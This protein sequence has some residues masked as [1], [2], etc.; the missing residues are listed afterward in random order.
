MNDHEWLRTAAICRPI[1]PQG[2]LVGRKVLL[3][4]R[5]VQQR[6]GN[7]GC[8]E[9]RPGAQA[10][11]PSRDTKYSRV[12]GHGW[13]IAN[14]SRR[15]GKLRRIK[16]S[17]WLWSLIPINQIRV[18]SGVDQTKN[19]DCR[20]FSTELSL[21]ERT[22]SL[23]RPHEIFLAG[24]NVFLHSVCLESRCRYNKTLKKDVP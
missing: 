6:T 23:L 21:L 20:S 15:R 17:P 11:R 13:T 3:N 12:C 8:L 19:D 24:C 9:S 7:H 16:A 1:L 4:F 5:E 14:H 2:C 22:F 10:H 18:R